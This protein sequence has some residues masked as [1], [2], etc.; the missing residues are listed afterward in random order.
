M[1]GGGQW[2][3]VG[4]ANCSPAAATVTGLAEVKCFLEIIAAAMYDG[5]TPLQAGA[6]SHRVLWPL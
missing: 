3:E 5:C 4:E 1:V 6:T 2:G